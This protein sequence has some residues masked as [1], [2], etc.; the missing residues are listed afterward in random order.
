M[1][2][3]LSPYQGYEILG[4]AVDLRKHLDPEIFERLVHGGLKGRS[5]AEAEDII[6]QLTEFKREVL[7]A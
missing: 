6:H 5:H 3:D 7:A 2:R 4:L 1:S